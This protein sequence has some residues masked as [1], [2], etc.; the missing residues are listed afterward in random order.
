MPENLIT[1]VTISYKRKKSLKLQ[2]VINSSEAA[3]KAYIEFWD[4]NKLD[5]QEQCNL[6]LLSQ[7]GSL[8]GI[9]NVASGGTS[10]C[11][12]DNKL[13]FIAALKANAASIILAHNHPSGNLTASKQ[14]IDVTQKIS[15]AA[16]ALDIRFLDHMIITSDGYYSFADD[17]LMPV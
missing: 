16:K 17:G 7:R 5:L 8:I 13:I 4:K 2:P 15:D 3:Y 14:D 12:F 1:E 9:M 6:L 10:S 11:F